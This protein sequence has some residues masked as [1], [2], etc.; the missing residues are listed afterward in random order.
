MNLV[1]L[2]IADVGDISRGLR[3]VADAIDAGTYAD[4]HRI[5]WVI[6]CGGGRI[7]VGM[8]GRSAIAGGEAHFI[9]A[10]AQ[11]KLEGVLIE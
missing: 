3:A 6:D 1:E 2:P 5:V 4:A 8:L 7:E 10:L 9:L 11:R